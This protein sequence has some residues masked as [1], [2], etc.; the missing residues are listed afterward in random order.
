[1]T[2][3][4]KLIR[5]IY[6][7]VAVLIS[8]IFV[9]VG[10]GRL[11]NAGLKYYFFPKAEKAGYNRCNQQPPISSCVELKNSGATSEEQKAQIDQLTK[12]YE[13][14]K[15]ENSGEECLSVERQGNVVDSMTMLI[16]AL[17]ICLFHWRI[18]RKDKEERNDE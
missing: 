15:N 6:L 1:M 5:T 18:I 2:K 8:L 17:P 14:W 12:D 11:L 7:Y 9:A 10:T 3:T 13:N 16:I 4:A